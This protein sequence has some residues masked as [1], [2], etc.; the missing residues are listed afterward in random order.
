VCECARV[1]GCECVSMII[2]GCEC[3]SVCKCVSV[4]MTYCVSVLEDDSLRLPCLAGSVGWT[5]VFASSGKVIT[6]SG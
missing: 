4:C 5:P 3:V 6:P 2:C 1:C